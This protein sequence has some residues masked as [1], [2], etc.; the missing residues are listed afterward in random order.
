V[1]I[2]DN[3]LDGGAQSVTMIP[4]PRR[5]GSGL[6]LI[7]THFGNRQGLIRINGVTARR[8]VLIYPGVSVATGGNKYSN[9]SV[10][11]IWR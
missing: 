6:A 2:D 10:I 1:L 11:R 5:T 7:N 8:P 4:G 3:W 9:G